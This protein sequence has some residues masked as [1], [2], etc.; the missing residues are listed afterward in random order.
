LSGPNRSSQ[1]AGKGCKARNNCG[2]AAH[3]SRMPAPDGALPRKPK[4]WDENERITL[5]NTARHENSHEQTA[6]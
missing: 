5:T 3:E 2:T 6:G 1:G 4:S